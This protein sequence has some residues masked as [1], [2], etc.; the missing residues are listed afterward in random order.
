MTHRIAGLCVAAAVGFA[1]SLAAQNPTSTTATQGTVI[2]DKAGHDVT[3]TGCVAKAA[4][5][6][7]ML[8]NAMIEPAAPAATTGAT[9]T[10]S[11]GATTAGT[12]TAA[13][14]STTTPAVAGAMNTAMTWT[15]AGGT[16]LDKHLGHKI[17]VMGR[18]AWD[19][20]K[21][22]PAAPASAATT[23][24]TGATTATGTPTAAGTTT[25]GVTAAESTTIV[26]RPSVDV[27]TVKMLSASCP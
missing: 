20:S 14:A 6:G 13:T 27:R 10:T 9:G 11:T 25:A 2:S 23:G 7:F 12:G 8:T 21:P 3:V 18:T 24:T 1:A 5:G 4:D 19:P 22:A 15:L 17:Q 26:N 16:D